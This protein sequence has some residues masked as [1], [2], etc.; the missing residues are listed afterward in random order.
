MKTFIILFLIYGFEICSSMAQD[1]KATTT[2]GQ[3]VTLSSTGTWY[4]DSIR[5]TSLYK[6]NG[7]TEI[8]TIAKEKPKLNNNTLAL[9]TLYALKK[10]FRD[11]K[12]CCVLNEKDS[13]CTGRADWANKVPELRNSVGKK[14]GLVNYVNSSFNKSACSK[15]YDFLIEVLFDVN[16][17]GEIYNVKFLNESKQLTNAQYCI[18]EFNKFANAVFEM[19][20]R[21]DEIKM[22]PPFYKDKIYQQNYNYSDF[23]IYFYSNKINGLFVTCKEKNQ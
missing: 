19:M 18:D 11:H 2:T 10:Y 21:I 20:K 1:I 22:T 16:C 5:S 14:N 6:G 9:D 4:Y 7:K 15:D 8:N 13:T 23:S 12:N 17:R 3:K